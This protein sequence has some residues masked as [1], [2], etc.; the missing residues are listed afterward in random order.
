MDTHIKKNLDKSNLSL[1]IIIVQDLRYLNHHIHFRL[2][3]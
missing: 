2:T 1:E 3:V